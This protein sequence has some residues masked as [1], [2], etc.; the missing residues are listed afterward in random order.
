MEDC[1]ADDAHKK[2]SPVIPQL[3]SKETNNRRSYENTEGKNGVHES[4]VDVVDP[5][6]LHVDGEVGH[7]GKRCPIEEKQ[8]KLQWKEVH[9]RMEKFLCIGTC[10]VSR[11][12]KL[13]SNWFYL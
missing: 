1:T 6:I 13:D 12:K 7:D 5:D 3:V 2:S 4:N 9:V 11:D 8:C 10:S